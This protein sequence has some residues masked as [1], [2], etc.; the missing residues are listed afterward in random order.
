MS[1]VFLI[2][3]KKEQIKVDNQPNEHKEQV[4]EISDMSIYNLPS[5]WTNQ[6]GENLELV[7]LQENVLVMVMIYTSC[8]GACPRL[9]ADMRHI[10]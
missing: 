10:E 9:V 2:A 7:D 6:K 4:L 8:K 3:C 5:T 1:I